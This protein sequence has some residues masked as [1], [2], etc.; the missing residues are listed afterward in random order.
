MQKLGCRVDTAGNG[1]EAVEAAAR[2]EYAL[3]LMDCEMPEMD[4]FEA[5]AAIRSPANLRA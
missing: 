1:R 5:A 2:A 3:I 4:G